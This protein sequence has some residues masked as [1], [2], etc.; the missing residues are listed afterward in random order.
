VA[1]RRSKMFKLTFRT[2]PDALKAVLEKRFGKDS[3][4]SYS[5]LV[6]KM[7]SIEIPKSIKDFKGLREASSSIRDAV[8]SVAAF[9]EKVSAS[10]GVDGLTGEDKKEIAVDM[11]HAYIELPFLLKPFAR[12]IFEILVCLV[13]DYL[14]KYVGKRWAFSS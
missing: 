11:L 2:N 10:F 12:T 14:N 7:R 8:E 4:A 3:I 13:V 1:V 5:E 6:E 9:L